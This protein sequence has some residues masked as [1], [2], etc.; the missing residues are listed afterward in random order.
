MHD[1]IGL[2]AEVLRQSRIFDKIP[3]EK[4]PGVLTCLQARQM[5]YPRD[6]LV[7][8]PGNPV[9]RAGVVLEGTLD[10]Y[11]HDENGNQVMINRLQSGCVFG[12]ESSCAGRLAGQVYLYAASKSKVF[13]LDFGVLLSKKNTNCPYKMQ[14][15][16]NLMQEFAQQIVFFNTKIRILSQKKLRDKLKVFLQTQNIS[17]SGVIMLPFNRRELAEFL[18]ADRS[19]L[20][21]ELCRMQDEGIATVSGAKITM[22][23]KNF[24]AI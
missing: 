12:A 17:P 23:D 10:K 4:Y 3:E 11:L 5:I 18:Y 14:V 22:L 24:L 1:A 2:Y 21:R 7:L 15:M 9:N 16:S 8:G 20:S 6:A 19:A 13:L